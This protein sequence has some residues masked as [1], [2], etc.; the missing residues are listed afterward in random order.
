LQKFK[1]VFSLCEYVAASFQEAFLLFF[2][3]FMFFQQELWKIHSFT[4]GVFSVSIIEFLSSH[5]FGK[6]LCKGVFSLSLSLF[7]ERA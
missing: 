1:I 2:F 4:F 5:F 6:D 7:M 3:L